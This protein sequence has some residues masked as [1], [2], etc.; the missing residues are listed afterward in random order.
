MPGR[1]RQREGADLELAQT[2]ALDDRALKGEDVL[3]QFVVLLLAPARLGLKQ[4][5]ALE[6]FGHTRLVHIRLLD[7]PRVS[8]FAPHASASRRPR[9]ARARRRC[10]SPRAHELGTDPPT[11]PVGARGHA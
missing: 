5:H 7:A 11:L 2:L 3:V 10:R 1:E 9:A 6:L 8:A 4:L